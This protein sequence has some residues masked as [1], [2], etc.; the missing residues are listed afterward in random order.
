VAGKAGSVLKRLL[1]PSHSDWLFAALMLWLFAVGNGWSGLLADGDTGWHIRAGEYVLDTGR[2][3]RADLF[4]FSKPGARWYAWEWLSDTLFA[5]VWRR[6]SLKGVVLVAGIVIA[7]YLVILF[8]HMLWR[9]G[10]L[11]FALAA[12]LLTAG[13]SGIHYL[14]RPHIFTLLLLP[15]SLWLLDR[16]RRVGDRLVWVLI[17][18]T[19][20]WANLHAGFLALVLSLGVLAAAAMAERHWRAAARNAA[21]G[22]GCLAASMLNPYGMALHRHVFEYLQSGWIREAVDEFQSPRFR[23]ESALDFEILLFAGLAAAASLFGRKKIAEA[24]LVVVWAHAALVSVRHVPV[25]AIVACPVIVSEATRWW[26]GWV[27]GRGARTLPAVVD[28]LASDLSAGSR[29]TSLVPVFLVAGLTF[30]GIRLAWPQDFPAA[31]FPTKLVERNERKLRGARVFTSD[32]WGDYLIY[33][34]PPRQRVFVDGR[35]DFYGRE[36][37]GL[38]L[39]TIYGEPAWSGTLDRY[40]V[41]EVLA[42]RHWPLDGLLNQNSHWRLVDEDGMAALF[43]RAGS[44]GVAAAQPKENL[45]CRRSRPQESLRN[46]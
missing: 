36:I 3:P 45:P 32:Q 33:R 13:A 21:L 20:L 42:D 6:G 28:G 35:S 40:A 14:A 12:C 2:V 30:G 5:A 19:A 27:A 41:S 23:S 44:G 8:R 7:A 26:N 15:V 46:E 38:Y 34:L 11:F 22:A 1:V 9:G 25:F 16:D 31:K 43:E 17:P 4:S 18:I 24:S 29:W 37:G 10:N 39:R